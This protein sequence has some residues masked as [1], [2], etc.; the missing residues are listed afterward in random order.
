MPIAET[1]SPQTATPNRATS[2]KDIARLL[3]LI[4][5]GLTIASAAL[6]I[7]CT[8]QGQKYLDPNELRKIGHRFHDWVRG[9]PIVAPLAYS[10]LYFVLALLALPVWWLQILAGYGFGIFFGTLWTQIGAAAGAAVTVELAHVLAGDW[11]QYK[12]EARR[13]RLAEL[14]RRLGHNG[15][16]VVMACRLSHAIPFGLSNY[17]FGLTR[18]RAREA[19]LGTFLGNIPAAAVYV[20]VGAGYHPWSNWRFLGVVA[21]IEL[22][23]LIPLGLRYFKP[24]WFHRIGLE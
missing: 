9:H 23:L 5:L 19:A 12:V 1:P 14:D 17:A 22:L 7:F 11:V 10:A 16:L 8:P 13:A 2:K 3:V 6:W 4:I 15:F 18:I 24:Q 21:G 20:A